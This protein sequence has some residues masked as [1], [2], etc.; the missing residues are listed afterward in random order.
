MM[1]VQHDT[2][3]EILHGQY[4]SFLST[5]IA[6]NLLLI[7]FLMIPQPKAYEKN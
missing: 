1:L 5:Q 4:I 3:V 7:A 2:L 6:W